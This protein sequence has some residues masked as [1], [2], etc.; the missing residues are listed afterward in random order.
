MHIPQAQQ[1]V[2]YNRVPD[3]QHHVNLYCRKTRKDTRHFQ[4]RK[5]R[6]R[7]FSLFM[8]TERARLREVRA[9]GVRLCPQPFSQYLSLGLLSERF[10]SMVFCALAAAA[11]GVATAVML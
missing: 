6:L 2:A 8:E 7:R 11:H 10:R 5:V 1:N 9:S 4:D 3:Q